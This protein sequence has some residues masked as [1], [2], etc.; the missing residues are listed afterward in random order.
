MLSLQF[1]VTVDPK[2]KSISPFLI[3]LLKKIKRE[4]KISSLS[5]PLYIQMQLVYNLSPRDMEKP[6]GE[7]EV[8]ILWSHEPTS[9]S[10]C[11]MLFASQSCWTF[12]HILQPCHFSPGPELHLAECVT[13]PHCT[14]HSVKSKAIGKLVNLKIKSHFKKYGNPFHALCVYVTVSTWWKI[15]RLF[16]AAP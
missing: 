2:Y 6:S 16:K 13:L 4:L 7:M 9:G 12:L 15:L 10:H 8:R 11:H 1:H 3:Q 14:L 5:Q